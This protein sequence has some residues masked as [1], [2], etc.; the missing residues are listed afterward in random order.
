M[1]QIPPDP[2]LKALE[3]AL[4]ELVPV[5]SRVNRD[6]LMFQAGA[7]SNSAASRRSSWPAIVAV[8]SLALA[9]ESVFIGTRPAPRVVE[10]TV[11]VPAPVERAADPAAQELRPPGIP[12]RHAAAREQL[13]VGSSEA[14][15]GYQRF[16]NLVIRFGLDAFPERP[17]FVSRE[18]DGGMSPESRLRPAG[19]LRSLELERI[20]K[21][22]D[23][24]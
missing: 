15:S 17:A 12:D 7:M 3:S 8:L 5:S 21:P 20:F 9:A 24:S 11:F 4:G 22:G 6:K 10:R 18:D 23:P 2:E 1:S 13:T 14:A 16:Q 19:A